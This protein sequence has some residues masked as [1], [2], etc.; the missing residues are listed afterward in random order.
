M[1]IGQLWRR[2]RDLTIAQAAIQGTSI[3]FLA[4][5][6]DLDPAR[7]SRILRGLRAEFRE[8]GGL[9]AQVLACA[10]RTLNRRSDR[11]E[12]LLVDGR[13]RLGKS[14]RLEKS[15]PPCARG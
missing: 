13:T 2:K 6:F 3:R 9:T 1:T 14:M 8:S 5:V 11:V 10:I 4:D 15:A 12:M 7:V